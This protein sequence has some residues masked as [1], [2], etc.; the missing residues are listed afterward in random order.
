MGNRSIWS[1]MNLKYEFSLHSFL[2]LFLVTVCLIQIIAFSQQT[3]T[4]SFPNTG[5]RVFKQK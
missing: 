1:N 3:F 4:C 5:V 2:F